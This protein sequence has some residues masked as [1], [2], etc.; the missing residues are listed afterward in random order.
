MPKRRRKVA[1]LVDRNHEKIYY[2]VAAMTAATKQPWFHLDEVASF[3]RY[4]QT[5]CARGGGTES[6]QFAL[7]PPEMF[8]QGWDD[9][10]V[11][12][13]LKALTTRG[14]LA[15]RVTPRGNEVSCVVIEDHDF[16]KLHFPEI[17]TNIRATFDGRKDLILEGTT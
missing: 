9:Y 7:V 14:I 8:P 3:L 12:A 16:H 10:A 13:G 4:H 15:H 11:A 2:A 1:L 6:S 5:R 17:V